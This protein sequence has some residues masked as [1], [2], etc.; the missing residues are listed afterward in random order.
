MMHFGVKVSIIEP[1]FFKTQV[2]DLGLIEE[3]LKKR[4][5]NLPAEVRRAYGDSYL[6]DCECFWCHMRADF[7][8]HNTALDLDHGAFKGTVHANVLIYWNT[9]YLTNNFNNSRA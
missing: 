3:D 8:Q 7:M 6:Q 5:N 2:T 9:A 4:W 1:G